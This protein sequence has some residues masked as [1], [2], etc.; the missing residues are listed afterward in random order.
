[1]S[2]NL[3][4]ATLDRLNELKNKVEAKFA[5]RQSDIL[6]L[7]DHS[8]IN[9]KVDDLTEHL[10]ETTNLSTDLGVFVYELK[11]AK[12]LLKKFLKD[13]G[14]APTIKR[15]VEDLL[16]QIDDFGHGLYYLTEALKDRTRTLRFL[17]GQH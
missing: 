12:V 9:I 14:Y 6:R 3:S 15:S 8:I 4:E 7:L 16:S 10:I 13:Q 17:L 5:F 1:M 2:D 11:T